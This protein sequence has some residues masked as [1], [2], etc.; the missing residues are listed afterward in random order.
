MRARD[1]C[2]DI[3]VV[4]ARDVF[5]ETVVAGVLDTAWHCD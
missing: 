4:Q 2:Q 1:F 5:V 3:L